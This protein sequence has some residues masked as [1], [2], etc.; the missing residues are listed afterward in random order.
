MSAYSGSV[1]APE[2]AVDW[3]DAALC[4]GEGE[5]AEDWFP[6]GTGS[7]AT[8]AEAHAKAVCWRCPSREHCAQWALD[9]HEAGIWGGLSEADRR[10][11]LRRRGVNLP[12]TGEGDAPARAMGCR[13]PVCGVGGIPLAIGLSTAARREP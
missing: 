13:P 1:P 3:R 7:H 12:D 4:R 2:R 10:T 6:V 5:S 11:I 8:A 9:H